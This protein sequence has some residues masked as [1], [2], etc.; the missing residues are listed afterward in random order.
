MPPHVCVSVCL[1]VPWCMSVG[2]RTASG[3]GPCL[4]LVCCCMYQTNWSVILLLV[5]P[6]I[7]ALECWDS[8]LL[9]PCLAFP[10][11]LGLLTEV[12]SLAQQAFYLLSHLSSPLL[13][14]ATLYEGTG[15]LK[16]PSSHAALCT[17]SPC[18]SGPSPP[19]LVL[20]SGRVSLWKVL[21]MSALYLASY[22]FQS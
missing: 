12:L 20:H 3:V 5:L 17:W 21:V 18:L 8:S 2:Q 14:L 22:P 4:S 13:I 6:P 9:L 1:S 7:S 15:T 19:K 11:P 16:P 10:L